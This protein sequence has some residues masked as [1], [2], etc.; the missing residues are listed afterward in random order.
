[1]IVFKER[2]VW[3]LVCIEVE[4]DTLEE[5]YIMIVHFPRVLFGSCCLD[6]GGI[7]ALSY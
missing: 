4:D 7:T 1:M 3:F 5:W 2:K 6:E